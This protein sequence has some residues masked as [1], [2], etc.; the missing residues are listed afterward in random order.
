MSTPP[1]STPK[2]EQGRARVCNE[3]PHSEAS[4]R[5]TCAPSGQELGEHIRSGAC[6][7]P[8]VDRFAV[9]TVEG[10][11]LRERTA[12]GGGGGPGEA[13]RTAGGRMPPERSPAERAAIEAAHCA[14]AAESAR[15]A[16]LRDVRR[17][18]CAGCTDCEGFPQIE[19]VKCRK[20]RTTCRWKDL[21]RGGC[22]K[23]A[24]V[25]LSFR[26]KQLATD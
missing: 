20:H 19:F 4:G 26:R 10:K 17:P 18:V 21:A 23:W 9:V 1:T 3:C 24:A 7:D 14:A 12:G 16:G 15:Q 5:V 8:Q 11:V 6:G 2:V 25:D 22:E 13:R